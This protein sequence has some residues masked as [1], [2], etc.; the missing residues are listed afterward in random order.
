MR[1]WIVVPY[2]GSPAAQSALRRSAAVVARAAPRYC[3]LLVA[4]VGLDPS[5][6]DGPVAEATEIVGPGLPVRVHWLTPADPID[7]LR[8]LCADAAD[9]ILAVPLGE[10]GRAPWYARACRPGQVDAAMMLFFLTPRDLKEAA[11]R[12]PPAS[13]LLDALRRA[14]GRLLPRG[15]PRSARDG[16]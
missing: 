14:L 4:T 11:A 7:A 9:A 5:A 15:A 12:R 10:R 8:W 2:D 16:L 1:A 3:G 13:G 6:L